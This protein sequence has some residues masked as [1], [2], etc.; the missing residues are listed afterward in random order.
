MYRR[1]TQKLIEDM[2]LA[3]PPPGSFPAVRVLRTREEL[4]AAQDRA[5]AFE[6]RDSDRYQGFQSSSEL[7]KVL[8]LERSPE[9]KPLSDLHPAGSWL[10]M[11]NRAHSL[12]PVTLGLDAG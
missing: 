11:Q 10:S 6:R 7:A 2:A 8:P 3:V 9:R 4:E 5:R 1:R 12:N